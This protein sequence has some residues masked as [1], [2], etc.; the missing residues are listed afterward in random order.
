MSGRD[1]TGCITCVCVRLQREKSPYNKQT[2]VGTPL[3]TRNSHSMFK[4]TP[5]KVLAETDL[6]TIP[7]TN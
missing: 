6:I 1:V 3:Y 4:Q 2:G 7:S 5:Y